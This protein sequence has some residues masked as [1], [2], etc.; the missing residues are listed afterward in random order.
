V[1][2]FLRNIRRAQESSSPGARALNDLLFA[3]KLSRFIGGR[4]SSLLTLVHVL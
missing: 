3:M 4:G 1:R 2:R